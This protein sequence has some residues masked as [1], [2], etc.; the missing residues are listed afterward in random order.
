MQKNYA[1]VIV[2]NAT[3]LFV[4]YVYLLESIDVTKFLTRLHILNREKLSYE[5]IKNYNIL[6]SLEYQEIAYNIPTQRANMNKNCQKLTSAIGRQRKGLHKEIDTI[7][8]KMKSYIG[9]RDC[10]NFFKS[11][12]LFILQRNQEADERKWV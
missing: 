12:Y 2:K 10:S 5:K 6:F 8:E 9:K 3:F 7:I 1:R 11:K 4:R